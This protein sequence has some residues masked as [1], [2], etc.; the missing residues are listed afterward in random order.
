MKSAS[1]ALCFALALLTSQAQAATRVWDG[2]HFISSSWTIPQ[3][4]EGDVAPVA[5][6]SLVFPPVAARK[7]NTNNF[8][9]G[10]VF[11][12]IQVSGTDYVLNGSEV[13]LSSLS[14]FITT[15]GTA[16]EV[17]LP[18]RAS[19][20]F[21]VQMTNDTVTP[22]NVRGGIN[23]AGFPVTLNNLSIFVPLDVRSGITG[24]GGL[25]KMGPGV[26]VMSGTSA[27]TYA[28][29]TT[30]DSGTL[31]V[32]AS[33]TPGDATGGTVVN[34]GARFSIGRSELTENFTLSGTLTTGAPGDIIL[35]GTVDAAGPA[36]RLDFESLSGSLTMDG[37]VTGAFPLV[38]SGSGTVFFTGNHAWSVPGLTI[39]DG[40]VILVR[41]GPAAGGAFTIGDG[42]GL[43]D[44][45]VLQAGLGAQLAVNSSLIIKPD[46]AYDLAGHVQTLNGS[47]TLEQG[48]LNGYGDLK[49]GGT[50]T[51]LPAGEPSLIE[52]YLQ[53]TAS[54]AW[55]MADG[56]AP[57]DLRMAAEITAATASPRITKSGAGRLDW[58]GNSTAE[59]ELAATEGM[60]L[61]NGVNPELRVFGS[62][63][64]NIGGSGTVARLN[65]NDGSAA[66]VLP[67]GSSPGRMETRTL[68]FGPAAPGGTLR[69]QLNGPSPGTSH[70]QVR[71]SASA[72]ANS[73]R[74]DGG[75]LELV[76]SNGFQPAFGQVFTIIDNQDDDTTLGIFAGL[77]QASLLTLNGKQLQLSYTGGD[78]NDV[79]LTGI[80]PSGILRTWT[81][82]GTTNNWSDAGNWGGTAPTS[83]DRLLFPEGAPRQVNLNDFAEGFVVDSITLQGGGWNLAGHGI[84]LL[85]GFVFS[86][87]GTLNMVNLA[88]TLAQSQNWS[89][90]RGPSDRTQLGLVN[91]GAFDL[92]LTGPAGLIRFAAPVS[93]SGGLTAG[94]GVG[95]ELFA[96]NTFAG[97]LTLQNGST[98]YVPNSAGLGDVAGATVLEDGAT[99]NLTISGF[100]SAEPFAC[101]GGTISTAMNGP[102][103]SGPITL[104]SGTT[105]VESGGSGQITLS[106]ALSGPGLLEKTG[107]GTVTMSGS[108]SNDHGGTTVS[109]GVLAL[110][111]TSAAALLR[112]VAVSGGGTLRQLGPFQIHSS[113]IVG[114]LDGS[115]FDLNGFPC[116]IT[117]ME[118]HGANILTGTAAGTF[119]TGNLIVGPSDYTTTISG[120]GGARIGTD[121]NWFVHDGAAET[122]LIVTAPL[123]STGGGIL[124]KTGPGHMV[125]TGVNTIPLIR[126]EEGSLELAGN[127][128]ASGAVLSG[129]T[130]YGQGRVASLTL[131]PGE[132]A[133]SFI[134]PGLSPGRFTADVLHAPSGSGTLVVDING[135]TAATGYDQ[136]R[137]NSSAA[138][139]AVD[140]SAIAL[141]VRLTPAYTPPLGSTFRILDNDSAD[142]AIVEF[143]G[144]PE[145]SMVTD[146]YVQFTI[147]YAGGDAVLTTTGYFGNDRTWTGEGANNL[148]S[149]PAN[150]QGGTV[151][152]PGDRVYFPAGAARLQNVND[153]PAGRFFSGMGIFA[154]G[155]DI[156][157][158]A[159]TLSRE[160]SMGHNTGSVAFSLP[161]TLQSDV[162]WYTTGAAGASCFCNGDI[163][164]AGHDLTIGGGIAIN[165][166][167]SGAGTVRLEPVSGN[168][169]TSSTS[170]LGGANTYTGRTV[171]T[172]LSIA[173]NHPQALGSTAN[174]TRIDAGATLRNS[175]GLPVAEPLVLAGT[176]V[177]YATGTDLYSGEVEI[178]GDS[179]AIQPGF[180]ASIIELTG[181]L[182]GDGTLTFNGAGRTRFSGAG[183]STF[184]GSTAI[185][186]GTVELARTAP[187]ASGTL[188]ND[189]HIVA[190]NGQSANL[191]IDRAAAQL[192]PHAV[193]ET[194][195]GGFLTLNGHT[196]S[197]ASLL[198]SGGALNTN[199]ASGELAIGDL[200]V[201]SSIRTSIIHGPG[202][203]RMAAA[204]EWSIPEGISSP[205]LEVSAIIAGA[206]ITKT[207]GGSLLST[208][209][210]TIPD[211][212][213]AEGT[214]RFDGL[215]PATAV[216]VQN[217]TLMG[218]GQL[219]MVQVED[220]SLTSRIAPGA[221]AGRL[222]ANTLL[223]PASA[224]GVLE[225]ELGGASPGTTFDQF[226]VE[227]SAINNSVNLNGAALDLKLINGF[228]PVVGANFRILNNLDGDASTGTFLG[229]P[230]A[231][232][233]T[234]GGFTWS[235][236]YTG[237]DGNDVV[238]T[239]INP[240]GVPAPAVVNFTNAFSPDAGG[241]G[242][243]GR[244]IAFSG[245]GQSGQPYKLQGSRNLT[246][247]VDLATATANGSGVVTFNFV[248]TANLPRRM[249]RVVVP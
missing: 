241:A 60:L 118:V 25:T 37:A 201:D 144:K 105:V 181:N 243:P 215:S 87:S 62:A 233:F 129:G 218:S 176:L 239:R 191:F 20:P 104:S 175:S 168:P 98:A 79:T 56:P 135:P 208:G 88:V 18:L 134:E 224:E 11:A 136:I 130:L 114:L 140:L 6:D 14:F 245:Q 15:A 115:T 206:A 149:T 169:A 13:V 33:N 74:L 35:H 9:A 92:G 138:M 199:T 94:S 164:L 212:V 247:W 133:T 111:K 186:L 202:S 68:L 65:P 89:T 67:G 17:N 248:D 100:S 75:T 185:T 41:T 10:T 167:I 180:A 139:D 204:G 145:G 81:G 30:V 125:S 96:A 80:S 64:A 196:E 123:E 242:V 54:A 59:F 40:R 225:I 193:V 72:V 2:G 82:G 217:A 157:G 132:A 32:T 203:I 229:Q 45:A 19:G 221:S 31:T 106:G 97:A 234:A 174:Q 160:F 7:T 110:Q 147:S 227:S 226:Q 232:T 107:A 119:I 108:S 38:R 50:I 8:P 28:G 16:P 55:N 12:S 128:P 231:S 84:A 170:S 148:W 71:I 192:G 112:N 238:V 27:S 222:R 23:N 90:S 152:Q 178:L 216:L 116:A 142:T 57:V 73:I 126:I 131:D 76:S 46:G 5:G 63:G 121:R 154:P 194:G 78:G 22:G 48:H 26:V 70:D 249:Y 4:W 113:C 77:P 51:T 58:S 213:L 198:L 214:A 150:W 3:N 182:T 188:G 153:L 109:G 85:N 230:E 183:T 236:T 43:A 42:S 120:P 24:A 179:A 102:V 197:I 200:A 187:G 189:I 99:L 143:L 21:T 219:R 195:S 209:T 86:G 39:E 61:V 127:S 156:S 141:S 159:I 1:P 190:P 66:N 101:S 93:G 53:L 146:G 103:L 165:G 49:L 173:I 235:I 244:T 228:T 124:S 210:N 162:L 161:V 205:D 223:F 155:Y 69:I 47:I 44:S 36:A 240:S 117:T 171:I 95:C 184:A 91:L 220:N 137:I 211:I 122:D 52:G 177:S 83:G 207:G 163:F 34:S 172:A 158:N 246:T 237:G 151:P 166:I 29:T